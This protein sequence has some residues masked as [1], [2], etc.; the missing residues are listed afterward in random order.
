MLYQV[1]CEELVDVYTNNKI[2]RWVVWIALEMAP[3]RSL[4][5]HIYIYIYIYIS[6]FS[7]I[8]ISILPNKAFI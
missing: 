6:L 5:P 2:P 1:L 8:S 7:F 4:P 3:S